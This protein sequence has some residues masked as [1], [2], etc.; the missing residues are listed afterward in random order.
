MESHAT[1]S[2]SLLTLNE[3]PF[4]FRQNSEAEQKSLDF[5]YSGLQISL[6]GVVISLEEGHGRA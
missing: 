2:Q 1:A 4:H 3:T 5:L 6:L